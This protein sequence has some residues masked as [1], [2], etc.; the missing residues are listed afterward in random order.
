MFALTLTLHF[1]PVTQLG[2][3]AEAGLFHGDEQPVAGR[4]EWGKESDSSQPFRCVRMI[5]HFVNYIVAQIR[6]LPDRC[7]AELLGQRE[8]A[9][10]AADRYRRRCK[11]RKKRRN[12]ITGVSQVAQVT[13][14]PTR[15]PV[16]ERLAVR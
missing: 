11:K 14:D 6:T 5:V 10:D 3:L 7:P 12:W 8:H 15:D 1:D 16:S 13:F 2:R 4:E 9:Q